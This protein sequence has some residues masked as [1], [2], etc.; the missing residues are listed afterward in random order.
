[1]KNEIPLREGWLLAGFVAEDFCVED[2]LLN[3]IENVKW[4]SVDVPVDVHTALMRHGLIDDPALGANDERCAWVEDRVWVYKT[5]FFCAQSEGWLR[6]EG[7]DTFAEVFLNGEPVLTSANMFI[8][9]RI[10]VQGILKTGENELIVCFYPVHTSVKDKRLP[11]GFWINY[12]TDRAYARKAGYSFGWDWA[13]KVLTVGIWRPVSLILAKGA[14]L[15]GVCAG[16]IRLSEGRDAALVRLRAYAENYNDSTKLTYRFRIFDRDGRIAAETEGR[17]PEQTVEVRKPHLWW[18]W[19]RGEPYL[20]TVQCELC[21]DGEI[22]DSIQKPFGI[23]TLEMKTATDDSQACYLTILNHEAIYLRGANWVPISC[24]P[25]DM[26]TARYERLLSLARQGNINALTVWG[27]GIYEDRCF[28]DFCDREGILIWQYFM[29]ACGEYPDFDEAFVEGMHEEIIETVRQLAI[30]PSIAMWIGNVESEMLCEKIN[31]DRP[32]YGAQ[33]FEHRI[34]QWL[35]ELDPE[36]Y[37]VP[38]SPWGKG[39]KNSQND[40]DT[41]NWD[42]WFNDVPY[43]AYALDRSTFCS[44]FGLH[45]L[46]CLDTVAFACGALPKTGDFLFRY[47][48]RDQDLRRMQYYLSEHVGETDDPERLIDLT[49]RVQADALAFACNHFRTRFP[50]CGGSIIW[51]FN[52]CCPVQSWS[53]IDYRSI[54]K[55]SYYAVRQ[56]FRPIGVCLVPVDANTTEIWVSNDTGSDREAIIRVEAGSFM[57]RVEHAETIRARV[58]AGERR[59]LKRIAMGGRFYPNVILRHRPRMYYLAA[60]LNEDPRPDVR[61]FAEVKDLNLPEARLGVETTDG[62]LMITTDCFADF[63]KIDGQVEGLR[64]SDNYFP[65]TPGSTRAVAIEVLEG[66]PLE[67]R[68]LYIKG[69]NTPKYDMNGGIIE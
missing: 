16:T 27:G 37:Y 45:A 10:P 39:R 19:D 69:M 4:L 52:D 5:R 65:M 13:P 15:A 24:R 28:Y 32:M 22:C 66:S 9:R 51:Q 55:A 56:C 49:M 64:F 6:F 8:E 50:N 60:W 21:R 14:F 58:G 41:H 12:S 59:C 31:L 20:Y 26:A 35:G 44:E 47:L 48:N 11:D 54:P 34:P 29:F 38:S 61:F 42:V 25:G 40:Y 57:G 3:R 67:Q 2:L 36:R 46:P 30:H 63:V 68:N 62:S 17:A 33:L 53:M 7:L 18:T 23:R 1:M 43:T